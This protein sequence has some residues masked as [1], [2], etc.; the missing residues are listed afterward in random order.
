MKLLTEI[1][2]GMASKLQ[3]S[4]KNVDKEKEREKQSTFSFEV[5]V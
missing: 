4:S 5:I 1:I 2:K 3:E